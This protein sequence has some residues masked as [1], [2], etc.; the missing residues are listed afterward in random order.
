[1]LLG[2]SR[3]DCWPCLG[4]RV[5][6]GKSEGLG[7]AERCGGSGQ[8]G[9]IVETVDGGADLPVSPLGRQT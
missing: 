7:E 9:Q 1:M 6:V 4:D 2:S 8:V 3:V 5:G